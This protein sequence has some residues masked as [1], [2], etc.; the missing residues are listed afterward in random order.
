MLLSQVKHEGAVRVAMREAG[1]PG[2]IVKDTTGVYALAL[3]AADKGASLA[4]VISRRGLGDTVDLERAYAEGRLLAPISHPNP[5]NLHLT[6]TGLTHL[7]SAATRDAMHKNLA[8]KEEEKLTDSMKMFRMGLE[9][10]K[11]AGGELKADTGKRP[12]AIVMMDALA[13][14]RAIQS[15]QL[16]CVEAM[17]AYLDQ[18]EAL[19]RRGHAVGPCQAHGDRSAHIGTG[20]LRQHRAVPICD[21]GVDD[22]LGVHHHLELVRLHGE[23]VIG[24]DE[25]EPLVHH[26]CRI[27][28]DFPPHGPV[29]MAK[30]LL[31][32]GVPQLLEA[33]RAEG[34]PRCR[35]HD[36]LD[37]GGI[38]AGD[39]LEGA[40]VL[41]IHR[42]QLGTGLAYGLHE[43]RARRYQALLVGKRHAAAL[44]HRRHGRSKA[45]G[46]ADSRHH[47]ISRPRGRLD[48]RRRPGCDLDA[49][50]RSANR[51]VLRDQDLVS[52]T[53]KLSRL[54]ENL[55]AADVQ[56]TAADLRQID[57]AA[58]SVTVLGAR[59]PEDL[60]R[61][62]RT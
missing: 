24:L 11:P 22:R 50:A 15:K 45:G 49:A 28:G 54:D 56:L 5:A 43:D 2:R 39:R 4:D 26:G 57:A 30:R 20:Q 7:G 53:T 8:G 61:Q 59:Y 25:L 17:S 44:H 14:S 27:D 19:G 36:A 60:A 23:Q 9:G 35:E 62:V 6:G 46:A 18:I 42:H 52:G 58:A 40:R 47:A 34:P 37:G 16:S 48:Q 3:E 13:L 1:A 33:P 10:G 31:R 12:P 38:S 32:R 51:A 21:K 55:A 29:G 41:R